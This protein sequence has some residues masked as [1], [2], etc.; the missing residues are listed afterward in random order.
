M[1]VIE[2]L[3][4]QD[5]IPEPGK[6]LAQYSPVGRHSAPASAPLS[7]E[8]AIAAG[9][10]E[11]DAAEF[12][13]APSGFTVEQLETAVI[14][15]LRTVF[16]PEIPVNIYDLGLIYGLNIHLKTAHVDIQMTLTAPGCPVAQTF[17]GEVEQRVVEVPGIDSAKVELVWEPPWTRE[18]MSEAALLNLGML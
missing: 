12:V 17:P 8:Q 2:W 18:R 16:D 14:A 1:S 7:K 13:K 15:A 5:P 10:P 6:P 3:G 11:V 9:F 4:K